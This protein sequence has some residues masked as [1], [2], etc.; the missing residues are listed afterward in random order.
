MGRHSYLGQL[1][2]EKMSE[3]IVLFWKL[4]YLKLFDESGNSHNEEYVTIEDD[5]YKKIF[6][7]FYQKV[8]EEH[9]E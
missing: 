2:G 7:R 4:A 5:E 8:K 1:K 3:K 9:D 6:W